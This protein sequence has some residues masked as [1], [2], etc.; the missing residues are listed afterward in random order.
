MVLTPSVSIQDHIV[1]V[2]AAESPSNR[3]WANSGVAFHAVDDR[4]AEKYLRSLDAMAQSQPP[5]STSYLFQNS[6]YLK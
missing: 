3:V 2:S 5:A 1:L 6:G 4:L